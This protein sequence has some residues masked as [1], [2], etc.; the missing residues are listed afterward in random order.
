MNDHPHSPWA[1]VLAELAAAGLVG[2]ITHA[3][4]LLPG[5]VGG[6]LGGAV[7]GAALRLFGPTLDAYGQHIKRRLT[8]ASV[9]PPPPDDA[10]DP[11][12]NGEP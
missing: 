6:I 12:V 10:D 8:R 3:L 4:A 1:I 2:H 9:P 11:D 5:W 7:V